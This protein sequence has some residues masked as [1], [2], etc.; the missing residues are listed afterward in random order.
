MI[1]N[2]VKLLKIG[3]NMIY[4]MMKKSLMKVQKVLIKC[5]KLII[6][7]RSYMIK[8]GLRQMMLKKDLTHKSYIK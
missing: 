5:K 3:M 7:T 1:K 2:Y 4:N 8:K 6:I